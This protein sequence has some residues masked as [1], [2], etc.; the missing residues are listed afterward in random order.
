MTLTYQVSPAQYITLSSDLALHGIA[1]GGSYGEIKS[2]GADVTYTYD[3]HTLSLNLIKP[4]LFH[5]LSS[6][7]SLINENIQT[8]L[9]G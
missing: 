1:V 2:Y 3:G 5:S 8:A 7:Q 6:F 9:K 4:P